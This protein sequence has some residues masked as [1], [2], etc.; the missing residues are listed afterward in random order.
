MKKYFKIDIKKISNNSN[1]SEVINIKDNEVYKMYNKIYE[2]YYRFIS[3]IKLFTDNKEY[4]QPLIIQDFSNKNCLYFSSKNGIEENKRISASERLYELICLYSKRNRYN[5]NEL[6]LYNGDK[7]NYDFQLIE[8]ILEK[9]LVYGKR[10]LLNIQRTFIFTNDVFSNERN[11]LL[12]RLLETYPQEKIDDKDFNEFK[13]F[14]ANNYNTKEEKSLIYRKI[15]YVIIYLM[16]YYNNL[17]KSINKNILLKDIVR[18]IKNSGYEIEENLF[19]EK[20]TV[21]QILFIYEYLELEYFDYFV[22]DLNQNEQTINENNQ[23]EIDKYFENSELLLTKN[24]VN[25]ALKKYFLRYCLGDYE[26]RENIFNNMKVEKIFSKIDIWGKNIF[27]DSKFDAE[28]KKLKSFNEIENY[29]INILFKKNI[30]EQNDPNSGNLK[31]NIYPDEEPDNNNDLSEE[32]EGPEEDQ[33][34]KEK[35][36]EKEDQEEN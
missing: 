15:Q 36:E 26:K 32:G 22:E 27:E 28:Q 11:N 3:N 33:D 14:L 16:T 30:A 19:P 10:P 9:E 5:N 18:L 2:I 12:S 7:I 29:L 6:N 34:D 4:L 25:D 24:V 31:F 23:K 1:Y 35:T 17:D 13:S 20:I 21:N 8:N